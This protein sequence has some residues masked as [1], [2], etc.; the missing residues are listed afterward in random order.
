MRCSP[1]TLGTTPITLAAAIVAF[2]VVARADEKVC[3][4]VARA[5]KS[6]GRTPSRV[7]CCCAQADGIAFLASKEKE[8]GV[9]K[10]PSGLLFREITRVRP[11]ASQAHCRGAFLSS[12]LL[13]V[14]GEA[15]G[16]EGAK[17]P[18]IDDLTKVTYVGKLRNGTIF[19]S[20][21]GS[22]APK[23]VHEQDFKKGI[24]A[25]PLFAADR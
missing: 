8:E 13:P 19:D 15:S 10:L 22:F 12:G 5:P 7:L 18:G 14:Q 1:I 16:L 24:S 20:A 3:I 4:V 9:F 11:S 25:V 21:T 2:S 23:E 6:V 17:S